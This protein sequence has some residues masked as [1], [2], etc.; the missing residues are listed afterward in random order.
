[1]W[2]ILDEKNIPIKTN[3]EGFIK[4]E[5]ENETKK[6]VKQE[7]IGEVF[8]STMFLGLDHSFNG[9]A[10]LLWKTMIFGGRHDQ[11][12]TRYSSYEEAVKGHEIAVN[13]VINNPCTLL[14]N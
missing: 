6:P 9:E 8:V 13:L 12:Q 1:M 10:P 4:W 2:Y 3:I 14:L 7:Y 11:Y 5:L